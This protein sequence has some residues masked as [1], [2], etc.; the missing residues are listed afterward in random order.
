MYR[1]R[2]RTILDLQPEWY[3]STMH[4]SDRWEPSQLKMRDLDKLRWLEKPGNI[5]SLQGSRNLLSSQVK[6]NERCANWTAWFSNSKMCDCTNFPPKCP[7]NVCRSLYVQIRFL[8]ECLATRSRCW[9][10]TAPIQRH[11][12]RKKQVKLMRQRSK[13]H[14]NYRYLLSRRVQYR[15]RW[16]PWTRTRYFVEKRSPDYTRR[17]FGWDISAYMP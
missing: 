9:T 10:A 16:F 8:F 13:W 17:L 2:L 14:N 4:C 7:P 15:E 1:R 6:T 3:R 12:Q 11:E 5:R